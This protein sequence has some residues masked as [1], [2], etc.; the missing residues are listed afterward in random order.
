MKP[1]TSILGI[2]AWHGDAAAALFIDGEL[3]AAAEEERFRRVKHWAGFPAEAARWCLAKAG[4]AP[5]QLD[6]VAINRDPA[7][8]RAEKLLWVLCNRPSLSI[9]ADRL[10]NGTKVGSLRAELAVALAVSPGELAATFHTVEH[11]RAH[12]ASAFFVSPFDRAA[13]LSIDGFG[14]FS[15]AMWGLGERNRIDV[16]GRV[17]FPHSLGLLYLALTQHLG[18]PSYGDEYK[19]MGLAAYGKPRFLTDLRRLVKLGKEGRFELESQYFRHGQGGVSMTWEGG[20]P[21][22]ERAFAAP[23]LELLGPARERGGPIE[24]RHKDLAASAQALYEECFFHVLEHL[25][26]STG[27]THLALAGGCAMNS[28]ANG[29]IGA[30]TGFR[31]VWI[32]PAAGDAGGAVGAAAHVWCERLERPRPAPMVHAY[33]GPEATLLELDALVEYRRVELGSEGCHVAHARDEQELVARVAAALDE[34]QVVGWFQGAMEWGP[35]ALG[36]RSIL[37]D[38]RRGDVQDLLNH[39]IK[40]RE[41]FRPFAPAVLAEQQGEWFDS[42]APVP[43]MGQVFGVRPERQR[44][45]PAVVHADGTGRLQTVSK[46]TNPRFWALI[47]AF[48]DRTGVPML[49]NTSFNEN[50]PIV[51]RPEE[52]LDCFLRTKMDMLVL[53]TLVFQR[54][55]VP[56][57]GARHAIDPDSVPA[58][59]PSSKTAQSAQEEARRRSADA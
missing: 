58:A 2:N 16:K 43:F 3:V 18:F 11:H 31:D 44:Q 46:D 14:D 33:L 59:L 37:A 10:R 36:N 13:V 40:R 35:R 29:R 49:V 38:P 47:K 41:S 39:K 4:L 50:E 28:L 56:T 17:P 23:L 52:A 51:C 15:S 12:L 1:H 25:Q 48:E 42:A 57:H 53:D 5:A 27:E 7:A 21:S 45:V 20:E 9:L 32:Q 55:T 24:E 34:G 22:V 6:H 30:A 19:V 26:R 8:H 54:V